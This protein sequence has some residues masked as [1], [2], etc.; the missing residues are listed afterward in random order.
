MRARPLLPTGWRVVASLTW[1]ASAAV[2]ALLSY[3]FAHGSP[4]DAPDA[5]IGTRVTAR[6]AA[7]GRLLSTAVRLGSPTVVVG[8]AV[9]LA[10]LCLL[11]G[12]M[13]GA[14]FALCAAP[15]AGAV[16]EYV[17]KPR[18]HRSVHA[19]ALLFPS[20]HTTGAFALALTVTVLLLPHRG[21]SPL[22]AIARLAAAAVALAA[23]G[24]VAVAVVALGWHYVTDAI[25]GAVTAAVVVIAA[26][27]LIDAAAA[28][29]QRG[30]AGT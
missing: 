19:D 23:A 26:A 18:V 28:A 12:R 30:A 3:H 14:L 5:A 13:R 16:T 6:L 24:V 27:A 10:L 15:A 4:T 1:I 25:G 7:H 29:V 2:L 11:V 8:G 9:V 17:L 20:G 21:T 22:P